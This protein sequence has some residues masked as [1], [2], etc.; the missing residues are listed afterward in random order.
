MNERTAVR[1]IPARQGDRHPIDDPAV[2][3]E[4]RA[5]TALLLKHNACCTVRVE[6]SFYNGRFDGVRLGGTSGR[7]R[8]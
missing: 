3:A 1:P 6:F 5:W 4:V 7:K 2:Q 8:G